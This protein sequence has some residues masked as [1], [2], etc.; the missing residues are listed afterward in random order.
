V[1]SPRS[2][3]RA[4]AVLR[5]AHAFLIALVLLVGIARSGARYFTCPMMGSSFAEASCCAGMRHAP[6][7]V[8][9]IDHPEC[10]KARTLGT[11]PA[12]PVTSAAPDVAAVPLAAIAPPF[13]IVAPRAESVAAV[14][15]M[16]SAR[17]GPPSAKERRAELMVWTS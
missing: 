1:V 3:R 2:L 17:A 4:R 15:F 12:S 16:Y 7:D 6:S 10:C 9:A 8:P 5:R 14:R 11:L 13:D